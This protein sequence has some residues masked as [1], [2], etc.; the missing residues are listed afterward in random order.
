M[1]KHS[2]LL[3]YRNFQRFKSTFF[4]NL[5]GLSTGLACVLFIYLWVRDEQNVDQFL[6]NE[7]RLYQVMQ[8]FP[9]DKGVETMPPTPGPL[10]KTLEDEFPEVEYATAS[11]PNFFNSSKGVLANGD[12]RFNTKGHYVSKDFFNVFGYELIRGSAH[13]VLIAR[14]NIIISDVLA[15]KLFGGYDNVVG[16]TLQWSGIGFNGMRYVTGIFQSP[17]ANATDRF[18]FVMSYDLFLAERDYLNNWEN[19]D[20]ST[21]VL[22]KKGTSIDQFNAKIKKLPALKK[23][24][25]KSE[26]FAQPYSERY[27]YGNYENGKP[28]G[29]RIRY[30]QLFSIIALFILAIGCINFMNL[31]TAKASRRIKEVGIKKAMGAARHTL[32]M[33]YLGESM[34]MSFLS[35]M[36]SV[37]MVDL[38]L[39]QFNIITG[40]QLTLHFDIAMIIALICI[41]LFTGF[42]S[43]SYPSL[44][45][46][47][48]NPAA[49]LKNKIA[50]GVGEVWARKGLV[51]FQFAISILLV[52]AVWV[53]Y[54]QMKYIQSTDLG[55][56]RDHIVY[57]D[58]EKVSDGLMAELKN[59][60]GVINAARFYHDLTGGHGG[61]GDVEWEGKTSDNKTHFSNLEVGYDLVE[62][63][64]MKMAEGN[65]FSE[66]FGSYHQII[67]NEAAIKSMGLKDP[68]GKNIKLWGEEKR[69]VGVV[70]D[71]HFESLYEKV[72][73]AFLFLIPM[74]PDTP[75]RLMV[76]I[77]NGA[78]TETIKALEVFYRRHNPG[79]VFDYHFLDEDYQRMYASE[80]RVAQLSQYFAT[81]AILISCLGLFG[82][83]AFTAERRLKEIGIRKVL[84]SSEWGIIYLLSF[85]FTKI[86]LMASC[87]ALPVSYLIT[88]RWLD[89]FAYRIPLR[90]W[91]FIGSGIIALVIAWI[92]VG[93]QAFKASRVNPTKCLKEE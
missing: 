82:L 24:D 87:I 91:Y 39:P 53:V 13:D 29:G 7:D 26:L 30:V 89:N 76:R 33:Q 23:A 64:G 32:I 42:V 65:P 56:Q 46:S 28:S 75:S 19:S 9:H 90:W 84:G 59:I 79:L 15:K 85:D 12:I 43:G 58:T 20:P 36:I 11:I 45:L 49:V 22:L 92:T 17:P 66:D 18:D 81:I 60:P 1:M 70:K 47:R 10:A 74:V 67:F 16:K 4:I 73:P 25:L 71:F 55:Y 63:M 41:T 27:L 57:F 8:N 83:A 51:V 14:E 77:K 68:V 44:Y 48:F 93:S 72:G 31:S 54:Q 34:L 62:T 40:K 38:L 80:Q 37:L 6:P 5:I 3:I 35:L 78:E 52:V 69:I 86:V 50:T 21:Y 88:S 61:T 2:L